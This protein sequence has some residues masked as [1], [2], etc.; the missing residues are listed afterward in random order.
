MAAACG[1]GDGA[2][3]VLQSRAGP[4]AGAVPVTFPG[5]APRGEPAGSVTS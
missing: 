5:A 3:S 2:G 1:Q 4:R